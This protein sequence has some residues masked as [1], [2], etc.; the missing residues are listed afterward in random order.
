[1]AIIDPLKKKLPQTLPPIQT[2]VPNNGQP[3]LPQIDQPEYED[4]RVD[5]DVARI[6]SKGSPILAQARRRTLNLAGRRGLRNTTMAQGAGEL[7]VIDAAL[8][9]AQQNVAQRAARD[10]SAQAAYQQRVGAQDQFGFNTRLRQQDIEAAKAY[11]ESQ[12]GHS[13]TLQQEAITGRKEVAQQGFEAQKELQTENNIA[14]AERLGIQLDAQSDRQ[15][16]ADTAA[17]ERLGV[18]TDANTQI[19]VMNANNQLNI[20]TATLTSRERQLTGQFMLEAD[21]TYA[22]TLDNIASNPDLPAHERSR[23]QQNALAVRDSAQKMIEGLYSVNFTFPT[24]TRAESTIEVGAP[25]FNANIS[26][27]PIAGGAIRGFGR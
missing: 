27:Q 4:A 16:Q 22:S 1:M 9:M 5:V 25:L 15:I 13:Q 7:A 3:P 19:A 6:T 21:R 2:A 8:P 12:F 26:P 10:L 23:L 11:E 24:S 17:L 18:Q 14:A 20:N